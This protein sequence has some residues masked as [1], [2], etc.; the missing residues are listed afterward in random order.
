MQMH[1]APLAKRVPP[2]VVELLSDWSTIDIVPR[3]HSTEMLALVADLQRLEDEKHPHWL[4]IR[5]HFKPWI[6]GGSPAHPELI[7]EALV[8]LADRLDAE[9]DE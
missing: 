8:Q 9:L 1:P 6:G 5:W 7:T 3:R 2:W 4:A